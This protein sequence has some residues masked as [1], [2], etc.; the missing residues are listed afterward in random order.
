VNDCG[1]YRKKEYPVSQ[2]VLVTGGAG[3][4][5][6]HTCKELARN[7]LE[8]VSL[9]NLIYGHRDFVKW[10]PLVEGDIH[11]G[12]LLD[13]LFREYRFA[14]V[15]HF[16]AFAYVGESVQDPGK[17][18]LNNVAG[19]ISL[20]EA[21]RRNGCGN[22]IF[23]STCATYGMPE[24][25]L[26]SEETVQR[27]INPYGRGKLM[28]ETV[29]ND[30]EAAYAMRHGILRY[31]NAAGADPQAEIGERHS[32]ETHLVPLA[33]QA[34]M[35]RGEALTVFGSDY[36]TP[37]G[38]AIRDYVHVSDLADAHVRALSYLRDN[39]T[40]VVCNLGTGRGSSVQEV[41]E[42]VGHI[43]GRAVP[44]TRGP[45]RPGDPPRLVS[46]NGRAR[47]LLG[48]IPRRSEIDTIVADAWNWHSRDSQR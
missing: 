13:R 47:D 19:T 18:Y 2:A 11:D 17:Y 32:P 4:I 6:S 46:A 36:P 8:P 39:G 22:I 29:L 10:G 33:I 40:S 28:V 23:S 34:A 31:F 25:E 20:L 30:Y 5:G 44:M 35:G 16:A 9:D 14:A 45:R 48:W 21:M 7:G 26:I 24:K 12:P 3:Y 27:P 42:T 38:T 1:L 43:A 41:V 37:D 15:I